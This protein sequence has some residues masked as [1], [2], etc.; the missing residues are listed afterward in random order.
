LTKCSYFSGT[1]WVLNAGTKSFVKLT[2]LETVA[3]P[4][5]ALLAVGQGADS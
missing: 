3:R 4:E 1:S 2:G 5:A